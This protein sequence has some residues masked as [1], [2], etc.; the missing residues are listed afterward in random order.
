MDVVLVG[1][2]CLAFASSHHFEVEGI[3]VAIR[4]G[5][6]FAFSLDLPCLQTAT[7]H[8]DCAYLVSLGLLLVRLPSGLVPRVLQDASFDQLL[9]CC[10]GTTWPLCS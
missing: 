1:L 7:L 10:L 5:C 3:S 6:W 8:V 4:L 2:P 9:A